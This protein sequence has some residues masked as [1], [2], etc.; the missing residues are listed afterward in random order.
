MSTEN[1]LSQNTDDNATAGLVLHGNVHT[2]SEQYLFVLVG[3]SVHYSLS[4]RILT[5]RVARYE[6]NWHKHSMLQPWEQ[7]SRRTRPTETIN[8]TTTT[9]WRRLWGRKDFRTRSWQR[10]SR[11]D[12]WVRQRRQL[13]DIVNLDGCGHSQLSVLHIAPIYCL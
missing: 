10:C 9:R 8:S 4:W 2:G 13:S 12:L 5:P 3:V 6:K 11:C 7:A 1:M